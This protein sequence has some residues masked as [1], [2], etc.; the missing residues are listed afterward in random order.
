MSNKSEKIGF[1]KLIQKRTRLYREQANISRNDIALLLNVFP[2]TY[3]KW[4]I[5][6]SSHMPSF[7]HYRF[8]TIVNVDLARFLYPVSECDF[9]ETR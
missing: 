6:D 7:Y 8:C 4:E 2:D 5:S 1:R 9:D 3:K